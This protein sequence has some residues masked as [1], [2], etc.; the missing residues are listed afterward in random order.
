MLVYTVPTEEVFDESRNT[1]Y[2]VESYELRFEH[3]LIAI[4]NW[5]SKYCK[6]FFTSEKTQEEM[7]DYFRLMSLDE[8]F[9]DSFFSQDLID[10]LSEYLH[11][12]PT[13]TV[14]N[15]NDSSGRSRILTSEVIYAYMANAQVP[16]SC[17]TW[18][19]HRLLMLLGVI[20]ELNKPP[21]KMNQKQVMSQQK[22]LNEM[23]KAQMG[24][25]G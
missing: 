18:N 13:A 2:V 11:L 19:I 15:S 9:D 14:I 21:K 22:S 17:E 25:K 1:F 3:S 8:F 16:Y 5:E 23:R 24:T 4:S 12:K 7:L 6:P 20:G 10:K